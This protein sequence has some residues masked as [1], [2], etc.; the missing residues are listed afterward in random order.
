ML[1]AVFILTPA[2]AGA[3]AEWMSLSGWGRWA[4]YAAGFGLTLVLYGL[5]LSRG[6][7]RGF[8]WLRRQLEDKFQQEANA[9]GEK[10]GDEPAEHRPDR[11]GDSCRRTHLGIS[12]S[13]LRTIEVAVNE[14]LHGRQ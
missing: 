12:L 5:V 4:V 8:D 9:P 7:V 6:V 11:H 13:A 10:S 3:V 1:I 2:L 14:R